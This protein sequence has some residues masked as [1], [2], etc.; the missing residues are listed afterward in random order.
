LTPE[1]EASLNEVI[2][3]VV[4][5]YTTSKLKKYKV[6]SNHYSLQ[7][8]KGGPHFLEYLNTDSNNGS[9]WITVWKEGEALQP[10]M[11]IQVSAENMHNLLATDVCSAASPTQCYSDC[12]T[13]FHEPVC[14]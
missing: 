3:D 6:K 14:W 2:C 11:C 8:C 9:W 13:S 10:I 7:G 5:K 1:K 4:I 12:S